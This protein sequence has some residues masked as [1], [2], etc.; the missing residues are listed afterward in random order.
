MT[1]AMIFFALTAGM[2]ASVNPCG[3][4]MLPALVGYYLGTDDPAFRAAPLPARLLRGAGLSLLV[5]LGFLTVFGGIGVILATGGRALVRYVPWAAL[6]IGVGLV[7]LGLALLAG[8]SFHPRMPQLAWRAGWGGGMG[9]YLYGI[10][11]A[12]ASLG[13]TLPIFLVVVGQ[14][15]AA[16]GPG[17]AG[18]F[19][20]IYG[21][22]MG[23]VLLLISVGAALFKRIIVQRLRQLVPYMERLS[24]V[25]LILAGGVIV[26][27]QLT[28]GLLR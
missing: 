6:L 12:V 19:F 7:L 18:L 25:V 8:R 16:A 2:L 5:T 1:L 13:C 26:Y 4:A 15:L 10:A 11:Y 27:T 9:L 20:V 14:A 28:S 23:A 21:L 17:L 24:A 3:F 22:G